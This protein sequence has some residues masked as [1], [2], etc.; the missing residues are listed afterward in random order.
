V[1]PAAR[2]FFTRYTTAPPTLRPEEYH[3]KLETTSKSA[4]RPQE[5]F[6]GSAKT[7]DNSAV[8]RFSPGPGAS[9]RMMP[10]SPPTHNAHLPISFWISLSTGC[11]TESSANGAAARSFFSSRIA[12]GAGR[13]I[14]KGA[15]CRSVRRREM[16]CKSRTSGLGVQG[17]CKPARQSPSGFL[18]RRRWRSREPSRKVPEVRHIKTRSQHLVAPAASLILLCV[19]QCA[20]YRGRSRRHQI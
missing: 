19:W 12:A 8:V 20:Q 4:V 3:K 13:L 5:K 18:R 7:V 1:A 16:P 6:S 11:A 2:P 15:P 17:V 14:R 10:L 9:A